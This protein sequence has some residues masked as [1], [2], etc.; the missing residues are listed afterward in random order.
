MQY[1]LSVISAYGT[2][3]GNN[4]FFDSAANFQF[5]VYPRVVNSGGINYYFRGW[6]GLGQGGYTSPDSTGLDSIKTWSMNNPI[7]EQ[8]RWTQW[9][10]SINKLGNEIPLVYNLFQNYPNPFNPTTTV[11]Y[12]IVKEGIVRIAVYDILGK[13]VEL[14][15]NTKHSPG[16]YEV[17]FN[18]ENLASGIYYYKITAGD[19]VAVKKM[20]IIK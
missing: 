17:I 14:L 15:A 18:A 13:Q 5:G 6:N 20:V 4:S 3:I 19:F 2:T 8:A 12:D 10:N 7:L 1:K 11:K 16:K 9:P